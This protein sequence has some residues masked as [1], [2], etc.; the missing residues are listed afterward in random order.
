MGIFN[1][2]AFNV[3]TDIKWLEDE[4]INSFKS[5]PSRLGPMRLQLYLLS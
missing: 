5:K 4:F 3:I 2:F 1:P